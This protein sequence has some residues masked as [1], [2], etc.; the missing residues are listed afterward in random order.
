MCPS[1]HLTDPLL[2]AAPLGTTAP[3]QDPG[4]QR[5]REACTVLPP[6]PGEAADSRGAIHAV[7]P[8]YGDQG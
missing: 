5:F 1:R 4:L 7:A 3:E 2:R 8:W 6:A